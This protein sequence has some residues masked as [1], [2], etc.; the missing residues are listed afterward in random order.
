MEYFF[1][2]RRVVI[3]TEIYYDQ[4]TIN[5]YTTDIKLSMVRSSVAV[6]AKSLLPWSHFFIFN[7]ERRR[8]RCN[9]DSRPHH[10]LTQKPPALSEGRV[11]ESMVTV[12]LWIGV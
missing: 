5:G 9:I 4:V 2:R 3:P 8:I 1:V 6:V 11:F 7:F 12:P 10:K